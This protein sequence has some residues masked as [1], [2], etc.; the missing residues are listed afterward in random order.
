MAA[1]EDSGPG[2]LIG[3]L[4]A[5]VKTFR[6]IAERPS[7]GVALVVL[8]AVSTLVGVLANHRIDKDDM[9]TM[10]QQRIEKSRGGQATPEQV[11]QAVEMGTK[12]SAVTIWFIPVIVLVIY[13]IVAAVLMGAFRFFGGSEIPFKTSFATTVHGFVPGIVAALLT[14]P[15][16]F[17][18][19]HITVKQ[20][21]G[22]L[23]A[24]NLGALAPESMGEAL[25]TLLASFDFFSFWSLAL[26]IIGYR[27]TAKVSPAAAATVVLV[28]W[29]LFV[30][31]R[32]GLAALFG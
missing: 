5:P 16:L 2:R 4:V 9:R 15:V 14:L 22:G 6:A 23:L 18:R 7:W 20:A 10:I 19:T 21:Q 25:R 1:L 12:V 30:A 29:A 13:L 32:V 17:T 11:D 8:M 24:S 31:C 3:V 27:L 26:L 28:L